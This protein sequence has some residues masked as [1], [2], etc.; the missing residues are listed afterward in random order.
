MIHYN[1]YINRMG[2]VVNDETINQEKLTN[3]QNIEALST[4]DAQSLITVGTSFHR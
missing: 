2:I 3:N 1:V 4:T